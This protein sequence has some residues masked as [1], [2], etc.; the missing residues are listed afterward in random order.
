MEQTTAQI[1]GYDV[2]KLL[3][4]TASEWENGKKKTY[5]CD[6]IKGLQDGKILHSMQNFKMA[7]KYPNT[8]VEIDVFMG[9]LLDQWNA[10]F[11]SKKNRAKASSA[12]R[13]ENRAPYFLDKTV[14]FPQSI[15]KNRK[16]RKS[17]REKIKDLLI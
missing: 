15:R 16:P 7:K 11:G 8:Y 5:K 6:S 17:I 14:I 13:E 10:T 12:L 1:L 9:Q 4:K 3:R 2:S